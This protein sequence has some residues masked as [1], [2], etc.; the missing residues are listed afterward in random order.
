MLATI[1]AICSVVIFG[2]LLWYLCVS[3]DKGGL[4]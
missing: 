4:G 1:I 3:E 2:L